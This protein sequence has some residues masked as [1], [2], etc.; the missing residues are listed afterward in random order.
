MFSGLFL[1]KFKGIFPPALG[2]A[3][4][5]WRTDRLLRV[6]ARFRVICGLVAGLPPLRPKWAAARYLHLTFRR[7]IGAATA[8]PSRPRPMSDVA[9]Q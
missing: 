7:S 4:R 5:K 6:P 9:G 8:P 2:G 3:G 1:P